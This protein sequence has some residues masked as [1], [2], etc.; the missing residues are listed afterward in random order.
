MDRGSG[1]RNRVRKPGCPCAPL[2][3]V[4][5][6]AIGCLL[7]I[8]HRA[9][10]VLK[11]GPVYFPAW[12]SPAPGSASSGLWKSGLKDR[13]QGG[14]PPCSLCGTVSR[15]RLWPLTLANMTFVSIQIACI[16]SCSIRAA[17]RLPGWAL[18]RNEATVAW[19]IRTVI[20]GLGEAFAVQLWGNHITPLV[21]SFS[22]V[23][24]GNT[25]PVTVRDMHVLIKQLSSTFCG[26]LC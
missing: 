18:H 21:F 7:C 2:P 12:L 25:Y 19:V 15:A 16:P 4:P 22:P 13:D 23:E 24:Q 6:L 20:L 8:L 11:G 26:W 3:E 17:F 9:L 1:W 14:E 5:G 10:G